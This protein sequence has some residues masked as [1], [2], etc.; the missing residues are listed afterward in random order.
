MDQLTLE[1]LARRID[2]LE[3]RLLAQEHPAPRKDWRRVVGMFDDSEVMP[4]II[5]EGQR[6]READRESAADGHFE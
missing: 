4:Q 3:A 5:A 6:I 2:E 1:S